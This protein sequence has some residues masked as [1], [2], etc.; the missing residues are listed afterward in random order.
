MSPPEQCAAVPSR[1]GDWGLLASE[2]DPILDNWGGQDGDDPQ[3]CRTWAEN[4][5][6]RAAAE[7]RYSQQASLTPN[8]L[9]QPLKCRAKALG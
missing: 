5:A 2:A 9:H 8:R 3:C 7:R 4:W 6:Q 1:Y